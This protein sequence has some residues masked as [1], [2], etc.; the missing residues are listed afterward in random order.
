MSDRPL[1]YRPHHFLCSLGFEGKGYS[2][3]FTA[4]MTA[5]V[6]GRL[7]A[8]AGAGVE[9]EVTAAADD[10]CAPCP[11]R[12]GEGCDTAATI[13]RLDAAH[14]RALGLT[15]G[16]RLSWGEALERMRAL[17]ADALTEI[18]APCQWL[19]YGMC[20]G[21]LARLQSDS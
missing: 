5:I 9:I 20:R 10:I 1:R 4:N 18:C 13:D 7:R 2:D 8:A 11:S 16:D 15:A 17:P 3:A 21:A 12:R 19:R 14:A 6:M